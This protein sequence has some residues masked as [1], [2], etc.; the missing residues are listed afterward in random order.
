MPASLPEALRITPEQ[1]AEVWRPADSAESI[2]LL[3][4]IADLGDAE[5]EPRIS[6]WLDFLHATLVFAKE[7]RFSAAKALASFDLIQSLASHA[8][9]ALVANEGELPASCLSFFSSAVLESTKAMA[10]SER[11]SLVDVEALMA[12]AR[13]AVIDHPWLI[14]TVFTVGQDVRLSEATYLVQRPTAP[15]PLADAEQVESF[16]TEEDAL[17]L[18]VSPP[19]DS[20]AEE[21]AADTSSAELDLPA[22][23]QTSEEEAQTPADASPTPP[24]ASEAL[25]KSVEAYL[26]EFTAA[27]EAR[28]AAQEA[29]LQ[30]RV[31][32][33]EAKVGKA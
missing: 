1:L 11:F 6:L 15:E 30:Q 26:S 8:V 16:E 10:P 29:L 9:N 24:P 14:R 18:C 4:R 21:T 13:A 12:H 3:A 28:Q 5:E 7:Q 19:A 25:G 20:A 17:A 27:M 2:S 22:P 33:L 23:E 31:D 32:A